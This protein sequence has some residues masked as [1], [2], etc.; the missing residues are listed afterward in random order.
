MRSAPRDRVRQENEDRVSEGLLRGRKGL[1]KGRDKHRPRETLQPV[2]EFAERRVAAG[3]ADVSKGFIKVHLC[4]LKSGVSP[5][6]SGGG[7]TR[8]CAPVRSAALGRSRLLRGSRLC[9][10]TCSP[11]SPQPPEPRACSLSAPIASPGCPDKGTPTPG[12]LLGLALLRELRGFPCD[13]AHVRSSF[14]AAPTRDGSEGGAA[15]PL[16]VHHGASGESAA[17]G[18]GESRCHEHS[19]TSLGAR[20][21]SFLLGTCVGA[22]K[23]GSGERGA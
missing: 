4:A 20:R 8:Q 13:G 5:A 14:P 15:S 10:R 18:D 21:F 22:S 2:G 23:L 12:D 17:R 11:S 9:T 19:R 16:P 1:P 6:R 7:E 3:G